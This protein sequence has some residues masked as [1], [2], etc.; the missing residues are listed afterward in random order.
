[1]LPLFSFSQ[2]QYIENPELFEENKI[3]AHAFFIFD[4]Q[5][6]VRNITSNP[7]YHILN[8][9]WKFSHAN[10]PEERLKDFY[11]EDYDVNSW[12]EI[13]VP[14]DWQMYGY[15]Y[16]IYTNWKYPFK[17]DKPNVPRDF[18]P[19]GSYKTTFT[20]KE[21]WQAQKDEII[22]HFGGVNSC[23][24][25]WINGQYLG[26]SQDSKL[27]S[28]FK[29]SPLLHKGENQ[30][31]VE[32][33]RYC[34]GT[35]LEDQDMWRLSGIERD[36]FLYKKP[37]VSLADIT[38]TATLDE[39][40]TKGLFTVDLK[41]D[42]FKKL[43]Q[44]LQINCTLLD[45]NGASV[46][47]RF[48]ETS[49]TSDTWTERNYTGEITSV[50][51][52][53]AGAPYL[54]ILEIKLLDNEQNLI[55]KVTQK[56]GF[57][58]LEIKEG[59][60]YINGDTALIKGVNRHEHDANWGHAVGYSGNV[61]SI[62]DMRKDLELI[63]S[64]DFNAIRT[65]HYPNHPAF[66]D[67]CDEL[68]IYVCD[69]ANVEAHWYMMFR[70]FNNI[71]KDED[72]S[73]A[74]LSRIYNMYQRD[75]NHAS[76]IMWSVGN[77]NGTGPTMVEAYN[78]LKDLDKERPVFNE[79]HFFLNTIG[80]QHSDF[81]GNMYAPIDKVKKIIDK[82]L[83]KPFIWIEYAHAMGNS[84]GNF[85][86]LW[87]FVRSEPQV[88]GGF[89]WDWR[90][91]GIWTINEQGEKFLGYGGHFEPKGTGNIGGL[92]GDGN[93]CANGVIS[94]DGKLH[95]G[96]YEIAYV[97]KGE[98]SSKYEP[99][100]ELYFLDDLKNFDGK[101]SYNLSSEGFVINGERKP[102]SIMSSSS[103]SANDTL[104]SSEKA[105]TIN[106][107]SKGRLLNYM[108]NGA[109]VISEFGLNFWRA[110]TDND[111]GNGMP[112]RCSYWREVTLNQT[113]TRMDLLSRT[114]DSIVIQTHFSLPKNETGMITY[115]IYKSGDIRFDIA[116]NLLG[117]PEIPRIG[118]YFK[119]SKD[120]AELIY[121]GYGPH[122]NYVDRLS[123]ARNDKYELNVLAQICPYIRPQEYGNRTNIL[124]LHTSFLEFSS[125]ENFSFS[126]WTHSLWDLEE[127]PQK[128]GKTVLDIPE[129]DYVWLNIDQAQMG[130][131]GDN[132]WGR[133]P[134][135][136][137]LLKAGQYAYSYTIS[138][139]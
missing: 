6:E 33:Y 1:M 54:Y 95:P 31:A 112:K 70:P 14:G 23:F 3:A 41:F 12:I 20:L 61:F 103:H 85:K 128:Q 73:A 99:D 7:N 77:E 60:F 76:I 18:N 87:D 43:Q 4:T 82:D 109:T 108:L 21:D 26:Y 134:Y 93:F 80:E 29:V 38:I 84:S 138:P 72:Y 11:K 78:M 30:I 107:D 86:D 92:Q 40:Y 100:F 127:Y 114:S 2:Y 132:S 117:K 131:G 46:F 110:P 113:F 120:Q 81:N 136:K 98:F 25:V 135:D 48:E 19:V 106:F 96:A 55:Q 10:T 94:A 37:Q 34:D 56:V 42:P 22:L 13:P 52:W 90:D 91:Q 36:V 51:T 24:F 8:G 89:I 63:K 137:Y 129:R 124:A 44:K 115:T 123:S 65:A 122:E 39:N 102:L 9:D 79:R 83:D 58:K 59:I 75:K 53:S 97:Q 50:K 130:V 133:K 17:A 121:F 126:A 125:A 104:L 71:T 47:Q 64:L 68:G 66:Y 62:A 35:Y 119:L 16:P 49:T 88:Q 28:E 111:F 32:V 116:L 67:L 74:I 45:Q 5:K 69:E 57:K 15:D 118:S 105:F 27:P 139:R 101:L